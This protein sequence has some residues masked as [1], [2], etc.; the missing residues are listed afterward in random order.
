MGGNLKRLLF[1]GGVARPLLKGPD[2]PI[3]K[4]EEQELRAKKKDGA[5]SDKETRRLD[6]IA[7]NKSVDI[8]FTVKW[9]EGAGHAEIELQGTKLD[10]KAGEWSAW[11]PVTFAFNALVK[12][13]GM[14]QLHVIAR[15]QGAA[16][17]RQR[18]STSTRASR[19]SRSRRPPDF[20]KELADK[21]GLYRTIGWAE[22][23]WALNEGRL[24]ESDFMYDSNKAMDD[25]ERIF[26]KNLESDDW[27]LFVAAIET[28]DR[29]SHMM[30]R[31]IDPKHPMYDAALAAKYG[32]SIEKIYRRADDLVGRLQAKLPAGHGAVRDVGPRLP[33]VPARGEPQHLARCRTAT[34]TSTARRGPKKGLAD[35]FGRG[36][37][38]EGVDWTQDDAPTRWASA[39]STS[40]CAAA[41]AR[42][43]SP[44]A[45]STRRSRTRSRPSSCSS[46]TPTPASR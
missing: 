1:E 3:L 46:P 36:K 15:G 33:L 14:V 39:R 37:F 5:L 30:W 17:L 18:P 28:T 20:S 42:A 7:A 19:P 25:R 10:L 21:I 45:R 9:T 12:A 13:H 44:R 11:V 16:D 31:L 34:W 32:D 2:N 35:L 27:D 23:T 29:V 4:Q 24:D 8:P 26:F 6:E 41:R 22:P 40:T 43:S 38:F